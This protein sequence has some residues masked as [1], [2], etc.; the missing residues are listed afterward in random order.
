[1]SFLTVG[2]N[3]ITTLYR[4]KAFAP[5]TT[6]DRLKETAMPVVNAE[7]SLAR[8]R[9]EFDHHVGRR[10]NRDCNFEFANPAAGAK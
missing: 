9:F 3:K 10:I 1:M 7:S 8:T 4:W 5:G 2:A 6:S